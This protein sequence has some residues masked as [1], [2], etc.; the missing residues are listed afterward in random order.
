[1]ND[2]LWITAVVVSLPE[3]H[4]L[5]AEALDSIARQHRPPDDIVVG[6]DPRHLGERE[7]MN[8]L[9]DA[10]DD[11]YQIGADVGDTR[12]AP[13][14]VYAFLHD[15]DL[16]RPRHLAVAA[17]HLTAGAEIV[18]ARHHVV[19]DR[20]PIEWRDDFADLD[21]TN[22]FP[23]ACVVA[24]AAVFGRWSPP[25]PPPATAWPGA[26][27]WLDWSNWRRLWAADARFVDTH[28][29][30]VFYRFLGDNG[31]WTGVNL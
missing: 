21:H 4:R 25:T 13:R 7:N 11:R 19:G 28:E 24:D 14:H 8:T 1:M 20:P 29:P 12:Q 10:A 26:G 27:T 9:L 22:W 15:D 2:G 6:V 3:R 30:T 17:G 16:W 5:L 31:S 23:P 18:V